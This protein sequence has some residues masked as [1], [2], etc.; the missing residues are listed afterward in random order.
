MWIIAAVVIVAAIFL[1]I[2]GRKKSEPIETIHPS[3]QTLKKTLE[4]SGVVD[5]RESVNLRFLA[6]G[7]L[8]YLGVKEGDAV[9]KWQTVATIDLQEL[10]KKLD[11][12]LKT[13]EST[14]TDFDQ[15]IYANKDIHGNATTDRTLQK[16]QIS[17]ESEVM[18]VEL[19]NIALKNASVYSPFAGILV[20]SPTNTVGTILAATDIFQVVNPNTMYVEADVDEA[21]IGLVYVGQQAEIVLDS[22][23]DE[24]I[25]TTVTSIAFQS[26]ESTSGTVF[27]VK[28]DLPVSND[29]LRYKLGMNGTAKILLEEKTNVLSV[30]LISLIERDG[31]TYVEVM[32][33][34]KNTQLK[35][36][37]KGLETD[38]SV[39]IISGLTESD[40]VVKK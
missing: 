17:L 34:A 2:N 8:V 3:V 14:R 33:A 26:A 20:S 36:V 30:P 23:P 27:K 38:E 21:D 5:A 40:E 35:E 16:N 31:K 28:L 1:F 18:S 15:T 11:Q 22:Y 13:Y 4:V 9:K 25:A 37:K 12:E 7:K 19:K 29:T 6:G 32:G 24:P 10:K 39:E